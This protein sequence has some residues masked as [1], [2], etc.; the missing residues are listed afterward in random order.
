MSLLAQRGSLMGRKRTLA[1]PY[2][3]VDIFTVEFMSGQV[4]DGCVTCFSSH[5]LTAAWVNSFQLDLCQLL[6]FVAQ[7]GPHLPPL[8]GN[9]SWFQNQNVLLCIR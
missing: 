5:K 6:L 2:C 8:F 1:S 7:A 9:L 4:T 3:V